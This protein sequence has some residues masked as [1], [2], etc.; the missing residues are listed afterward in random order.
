MCSLCEIAAGQTSHPGE[1]IEKTDLTVVIHHASP[2][3]V[4]GW[5]IV[6]PLRHV[7]DQTLL[8]PEEQRE[9]MNLQIAYTESLKK[10]T[11]APR[12][13]WM[14]FSELTPHI[15]FHLVPRRVDHPEEFRGPNIFQTPE[16]V[17]QEEIEKI[18][19]EL[20]K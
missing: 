8:N 6:Y 5:L 2:A 13:Y 10:I 18:V 12:V 17:N 20:K 19:R 7:E 9:I 16:P 3:P 1:I 15:H 4:A 14:C 11:G